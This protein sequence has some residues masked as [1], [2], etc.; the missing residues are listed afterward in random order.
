MMLEIGDI[1]PDVTALQRQLIRAG[2]PLDPD[3][4]FGEKTEA[5]VIKFQTKCGLVVDGKVGPK[6]LTA[7]AGQKIGKLLKENDLTLAA[8]KLGVDI[9][10]IKAI[11]AVESRGLGF[12]PDGRPK[13]LFERHV[14][15]KQLEDRGYDV[16][17]L[18]SQYPNIINTKPGGYAGQHTEHKRLN[19]AIAINQDAALCSASWGIF[20]IM[21]FHWQALGYDSAEKFAQ[22]M[23]HSEGK[24]LDAFVR[25]IQS[26][27][28]LHQ[29][30]IEQKW[31]Q[32]AK[33]YNGPAYKKN[34]YDIKLARAY[35]QYTANMEA[36]A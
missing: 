32:F 12:L 30:L 35:A 8:Q 21:G 36:A 17:Q 13:I 2:Y 1:G 26:N 11:N 4:V 5:A 15:F 24:Q 23:H 9:A 31:A 28:K 20:Q 27:Q 34:L 33:M 29:A 18:A 7:L 14:M 16:E 25:F 6:T 10:S 19:N 22:A 3:G